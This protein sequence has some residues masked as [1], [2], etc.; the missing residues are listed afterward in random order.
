MYRL[1]PLKVSIEHG[2]DRGQGKGVS[3]WGMGQDQQNERSKI[4]CGHNRWS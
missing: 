3:K 2:Q 1:P 4:V